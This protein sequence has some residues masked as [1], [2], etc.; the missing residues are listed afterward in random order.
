MK[1]KDYNIFGRIISVI[2]ND[3]PPKLS[4]NFSNK[5]MDK[6]ISST[7]NN[8]KPRYNYINIAASIFIA[9]ITS[10]T[11]VNYN[12]PE[13]N[14]SNNYVNDINQEDN[15]LIKR[16]IDKESCKDIKDLEYKNNDKCK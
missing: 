3:Y 16:V 1:I 2:N 15:K 10:Y 9:L 8:N 6:I 11:L 13:D 14:I 5:V 4:K 7:A 12:Q